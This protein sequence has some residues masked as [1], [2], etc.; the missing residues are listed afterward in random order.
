MFE[1]VNINGDIRYEMTEHVI[2][3]AAEFIRDIGGFASLADIDCMD[4]IRLE[5]AFYEDDFDGVYRLEY[6]AGENSGLI[7]GSFI[8]Y[9]AAEIWNIMR[10]SLDTL[11]MAKASI[12]PS[13]YYLYSDEKT[14]E[15][16]RTKW[17]ID[18]PFETGKNLY[19]A[20]TL[21]YDKLIKAVRRCFRAYKLYE[22]IKDFRSDYSEFYRVPVPWDLDI[23]DEDISPYGHLQ[24]PFYLGDRYYMT[25]EDHGAFHEKI[26]MMEGTDAV[27][28]TVYVKKDLLCR[29]AAV[30][31]MCETLAEED[32]GEP[33]KSDFECSQSFSIAEVR[34]EERPLLHKDEVIA[35]LHYIKP[36]VYLL[37]P[38][39]VYMEEPLAAMSDSSE[40]LKYLIVTR[41]CDG[42][43]SFFAEITEKDGTG[44]EG[45]ATYQHRLVAWAGINSEDSPNTTHN[46]TSEEKY[47]VSILYELRRLLPLVV[48]MDDWAFAP[49][50]Q[51][52][53]ESELSAAR[54]REE[55][56]FCKLNEDCRRIISI[57]TKWLGGDSEAAIE[58]VSGPGNKVLNLLSRERPDLLEAFLEGRDRELLE[59]IYYVQ[60]IKNTSYGVDSDKDLSI[61]RRRLNAVGLGNPPGCRQ[62]TMMDMLA[63]D[64]YPERED[65]SEDGIESSQALTA[66]MRS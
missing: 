44:N 64:S 13:V 5:D 10:I 32:I 55:S 47:E 45:R 2:P 17:T 26:F 15:E 65:V 40:K 38:L 30:S 1:A 50:L 14:P 8:T 34:G 51:R 3:A 25:T 12:Y 53:T 48:A 33:Y 28:T 59:E 11:D 7:T 24:A 27:F 49:S 42:S 61:V 36:D 56:R 35:R 37:Q 9:P 4:G 60:R 41:D 19:E 58:F 22:E 54:E 57:V 62:I 21:A 18:L 46:G 23:R 31:V 29:S 6:K 43:Y 63:S 66:D 39:D 20:F 52:E 16:E